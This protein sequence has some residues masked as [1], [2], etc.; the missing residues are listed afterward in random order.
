MLVRNITSYIIKM[1][2][3]GGGGGGSSGSG[4][5]G[6]DSSVTL[7]VDGNSYTITAGGGQGGQ[8]GSNG[9]NGGQGGTYTIPAAIF[10]DPRFTFAVT[11]NGDTGDTGGVGNGATPAGGLAPVSGWNDRGNGGNGSYDEFTAQGSATQSWF[12][13]NGSSGSI[14]VNNITGVQMKKLLQLYM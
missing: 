9:G 3:G 2:G 13:S 14:D 7:T 4:G 1:A 6:F 12:Y 8:A 5:N 11:D 10:N